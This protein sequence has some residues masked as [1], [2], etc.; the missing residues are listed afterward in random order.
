MQNHPKVQ[1]EILK[2]NKWGSK[3]RIICALIWPLAMLMFLLAFFKSAFK[4][5]LKK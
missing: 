2:D 1:E 4:S 5:I 3:E